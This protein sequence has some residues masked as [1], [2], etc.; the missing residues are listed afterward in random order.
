MDALQRVTDS[1]WYILGQE[2]AKFEQEFAAYLRTAHCV[3]NANGTDAIELALR[4][5]GVGAGDE[6]LLA[7]NAGMY[8][9]VATFAVAAAPCYCDIGEGTFSLG[10]NAV[11]EALN[12]RVKAVILTHLYGAA[13]EV[14][15]LSEICRNRNIALI[16]DCAE[17]HGARID[18]KAL[19]TWG[20]I[21]C[22][23]FYP[24]KNLGALGDG[25]ACVTSSPELAARLRQLRQYGWQTRYHSLLEGGRNSRL[26]EMQ[27]AI[28]RVKLGHLETWN[29]RRRRIA[30][31]YNAAFAKTKLQVPRIQD[32]GYVGHLYVVRTRDREL[33][34]ERLRNVGVATDVHFPVP[35]HRQ[36]S[37]VSRLKN[38]FDLPETEA[39]CATVM[40]LPCFPELSDSEVEYVANAVVQAVTDV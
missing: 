26:D 14:K 31:Y 13:G 34:R 25:G 21:G 24:T 4:A 11:E 27:A 20:D 37:V 15:Q 38:E 28:L 10:A 12:P 6:V 1:G 7:A 36:K 19:G 9:T 16:E 8:G 18:G 22:F 5:V 17:C 32:E 39:N 3:S 33:I 30:E 23:S 29:A 2:V 35:D 40:T